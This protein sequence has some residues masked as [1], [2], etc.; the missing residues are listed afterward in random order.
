MSEVDLARSFYGLVRF[1]LITEKAVTDVEAKSKVT[2][3][4]DQGTTKGKIKRVIEDYFEVGV[5]KVNT[6]ITPKGNK[7]A[8]ITLKSKDDAL[9]IAIAL[10][11]I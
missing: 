5:L 9:K 11:I 2:L 3:I 7:K 4:V 1:P 6:L 10:G 8:V